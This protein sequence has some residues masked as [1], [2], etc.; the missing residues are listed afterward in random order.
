MLSDGGQSIRIVSYWS[1]TGARADANRCSRASTRMSSISAAVRS[2]V[3]GSTSQ[4]L[5][6]ER[7]R[8]S[9]TGRP[10]TS[11]SNTLLSS[12]YLSIPQ[13]MV[14]LPCGSRSTSSTRLPIMASAAARLTQV[15]VFPT[16][17]FWLAMAMQRVIH[18]SV[19]HR[20]ES[21]SRTSPSAVDREMPLLLSDVWPSTAQR[22]ELEA[23][24]HIIGQGRG[25]RQHQHRPTT[26]HTVRHHQLQEFRR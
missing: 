25:A 14:A 24:R 21:D 3:A 16:P 19:M 11:T 6:S 18:S 4:P 1:D 15:V 22:L 8:T 7:T 9:L 23:L 5:A 10:S 17:P 26:G 13:P 20:A 12:A 2:A